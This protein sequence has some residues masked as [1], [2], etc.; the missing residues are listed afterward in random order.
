MVWA[1]DEGGYKEWTDI[2]TIITS[3]S[4]GPEEQEFSTPADTWTWTHNRGYRPV[5]QVQST[6]REVILCQIEHASVNQ[7]IVRHTYNTTG[8]IVIR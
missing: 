3:S 8:F 5:V 4:S 7:I 6:S 2:S 1:T